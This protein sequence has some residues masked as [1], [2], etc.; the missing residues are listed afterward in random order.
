MF[1]LITYDEDGRPRLSVVVENKTPTLAVF[2]AG[3]AIFPASNYATRD[4]RGIYPVLDFDD[5]TAESI[6]FVGVMPQQYTGNGLGVYLFF[7]MTSAVS[8]DVDWSVK[9][10][11]LT[12][13]DQDIDSTSFSSATSVTNTAVPTNAGEIASTS[14]SIT[15][16]SNMDNIVAGDMFLLEIIRGATADTASGDAELLGVEIRGV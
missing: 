13:F 15:S 3:N 9:F 7:T 8:G 14:I 16:G 6:Y 11:R 2:V 1:D 5:T 12:T 10:E 4:I